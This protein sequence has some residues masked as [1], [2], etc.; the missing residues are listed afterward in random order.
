MAA[1]E[2]TSKPRTPRR[3]TVKASDCIPTYGAGAGVLSFRH[4]LGCRERRV[5]DRALA[6]VGR[7]L[8]QPGG[9][10]LPH[11]TR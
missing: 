10:N 3:R 1:V 8:R 7:C 5:I 4:G 9:L 11:L 6:I 2:S